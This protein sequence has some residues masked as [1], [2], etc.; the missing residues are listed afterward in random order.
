[1]TGERTD[2]CCV[3]LRINQVEKAE[4]FTS[5]FRK[6]AYMHEDYPNLVLVIYDGD[7]KVVNKYYSHGNATRKEKTDKA[8]FEASRDIEKVRNCQ[9]FA[10]ETTLINHD[11]Q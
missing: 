6:R 4:A 1:M 7:D 8:A 11:A 9:R 5:D 2:T 10:R 3:K